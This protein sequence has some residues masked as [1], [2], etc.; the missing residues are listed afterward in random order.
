LAV[1]AEEKVF[2]AREVEGAERKKAIDLIAAAQA[3]EKEA[4]R[5]RLAVDA[6]K[7]AASDRGEA[8]KTQALAEAEAEQ[9]RLVGVRVRAEVEAEAARLMNESHNMLS[10]EARTSLFRQKLLDKMEAIIRESAR[11]MER[12]E[13]IKIL[14]VN[15]LGSNGTSGGERAGGLPEQV[16]DSAL[17]FRAQ[18]PLIDSLLKEIGI[19]GGVGSVPRSMLSPPTENGA[20]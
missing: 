18:A 7:R 9:T 6:E 20:A 8:I 10:P 3:G 11:P 13:G 14:S 2:T 17:R 15:G 4:L 1:V 16:V 19:E 12:I 5:L